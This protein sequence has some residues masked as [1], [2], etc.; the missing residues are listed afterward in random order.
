MPIG[1]DYS[2][3]VPFTQW[4][5]NKMVAILLVIFSMH[6]HEYRFCNDCKLLYMSSQGFDWREVNFDWHN[7]LW[8]E[9]IRSPENN[10]YCYKFKWKM[11]CGWDEN[12]ELW[13]NSPFFSPRIHKEPFTAMY[14][15]PL[16]TCLRIQIVLREF[17]GKMIHDGARFLFSFT[18]CGNHR[19]IRCIHF[20]NLDDSVYQCIF[21]SIVSG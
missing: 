21:L 8:V 15:I 13:T 7:V 19:A 11:I 1:N 16:V 3:S 2:Y 18:H 12:T 9:Y 10:F 17:P 5:P 20:V 4:S 14:H 6:F